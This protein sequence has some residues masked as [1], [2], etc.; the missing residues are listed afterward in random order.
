MVRRNA[1]AYAQLRAP[2]GPIGRDLSRRGV[3]VQNRA[4]I[5][6]P[7]LHGRLRASITVS[8]PYSI[9]HGL[10]VQIGTNVIY[11]RAVHE[12]AGSPFAPR[13]WRSAGRPPARRFLTNALTAARS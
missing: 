4:K 2:N 8:A 7:V 5:L 13:S 10:A 9:P 3:R 1:A 12:G 11:A 6:A